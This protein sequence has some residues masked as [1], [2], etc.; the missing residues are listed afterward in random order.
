MRKERLGSPESHVRLV[1]KARFSAK[2]LVIRSARAE[3][4]IVFS[5]F[6]LDISRDSGEELVIHTMVI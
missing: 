2:F 6:H 1:E 5:D 3:P 4:G